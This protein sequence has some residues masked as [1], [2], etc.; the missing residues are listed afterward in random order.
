MS[1]LVAWL[2]LHP[3]FWPL[4]IFCA[5]VVD[6]SIGTLRTIC[7]VRGMRITAAVLG[8]FEV[9][10]WVT[11]ISGVLRHMDH[12]YNIMAYAGGFATGNALG[13]LIE[14]KVAIGMQMIRV[15]SR[16]Q[17]AAVAAGLRLAG[18]AVTEVKG[19]GLHGQVSISFVVA[20][21]KQTPQVIQV[22]HSIDPE[23]VST[24]EDVRSARLHQLPD[25]MPLNGWRNILKKK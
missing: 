7:V 17:S 22:A 3:L 9:S 19:Q 2:D 8:F 1:D 24:V 20:P 5:R 16:S 11:A 23:A 4:F 13:I 6:V 21:R 25:G 12:W 15:I 10:I 18:Y 14:Q